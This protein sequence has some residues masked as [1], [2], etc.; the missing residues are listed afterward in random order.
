MGSLQ[1][2]NSES[3]SHFSPDSM[4]TL[5]WH[6]SSGTCVPSGWYAQTVKVDFESKLLE[7]ATI[8]G[9]LCHSSTAPQV[10]SQQ[11]LS[12]NHLKR[13]RSLVK[14]ITYG[15]C[16]GSLSVGGGADLIKITTSTRP[17]SIIIDNDCIQDQASPNRF[18][19]KSD[20]EYEAL[21]EY[22]QS[23]HPSISNPTIF[24]QASS[25]EFEP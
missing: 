23:L 11:A 18:E 7:I 16:S 22:I 19:V 10:I 4:T 9:K 3:E 2:C 15:N 8:P 25:T 20:K 14:K 17:D 5:E 6:H 24:N 21:K 1:G 12:K 13:I